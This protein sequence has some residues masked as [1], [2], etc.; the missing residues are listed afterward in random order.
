MR[1]ERDSTDHE[2]A[3]WIWA[4]NMLCLFYFFGSTFFCQIV[5]LNMLIAIMSATFDRHNEDLQAN[6]MRQ[7]LVLQAEFIKLVDFYKKIIYR[8]S[9]SGK[10]NGEN[11]TGAGSMGFL[12]VIQPA[13]G[14]D[15]DS[16]FAAGPSSSTSSDSRSSGSSSLVKRALD[17]KFRELDNFLNK[18][19]LK[20]I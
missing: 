16:Q 19:M 10:R 7:K 6:A 8:C 1:L 12:F 11:S 15:D 4:E 17:D 18:K 2:D 13:S 3:S 20:N 14:Q 9:G 5:I